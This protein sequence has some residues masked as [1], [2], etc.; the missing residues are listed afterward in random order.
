VETFIQK[1]QL[2]QGVIALEPLFI[3]PLQY[4]GRYRTRTFCKGRMILGRERFTG[5][6]LHLSSDTYYRGDQD[7]SGS[8]LLALSIERDFIA[9]WDLIGFH[10]AIYG[11]IDGAMMS[12]TPFNPE[13]D[14]FRLTEGLG[15]RL[16]NP[17]L[18]WKSIQLQVAWNQG[19]GQFGS[20]K[21]S[22]S[23]KLPVYLLDF[24]GRRPK[25]YDFH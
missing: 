25:P 15:I 6:T 11:F 2:E 1:D 14:D 19:E 9:P 22:L 8:S 4:Y 5:E 12:D 13:M 21:F 7:L 23:T 16:R 20:P 18:V 10:F 24:E 3:T 17:R